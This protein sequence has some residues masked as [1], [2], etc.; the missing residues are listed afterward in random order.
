MIHHSDDKEPGGES[1]RKTG[2]KIL[3]KTCV[4]FKFFGGSLALRIEMIQLFFRVLHSQ[5]D[6]RVSQRAKFLF[7]TIDGFGHGRTATVP[8][9]VAGQE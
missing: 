9:V 2:K 3:R 6:A 4:G 1:A 8:G 7:P 5:R